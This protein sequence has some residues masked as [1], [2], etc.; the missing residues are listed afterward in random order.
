MPIAGL[1]FISIEAKK[2]SNFMGKMKINSTPKI[3]SIKEAKAPLFKNDALSFSF[4][5]LTKYEPEVAKI[6]IEGELLFLTEK[7]D[8]IL[9]LWEKERKIPQDVSIQV[10]NHIFNVCLTKIIT[11]ATDLQLPPPIPFPRVGP[12]PKQKEVNYIG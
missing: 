9:N 12:K 11:I 5:F 10:I 3:T 7:K 4:E 6:K 8:E 1:R 2:E